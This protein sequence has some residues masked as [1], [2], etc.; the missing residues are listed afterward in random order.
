MSAVTWKSRQWTSSTAVRSMQML[1][2]DAAATFVAIEAAWWIRF[3]GRVPAAD[4][5]A[6]AFSV[7]VVVCARVL[8]LLAAG[9]HRWSF[10]LPGRSEAVRLLV[11]Q[12]AASV[13]FYLLMVAFGV[14][15]P[16]SIYPLEFLVSSLLIVGFRYGPDVFLGWRRER[17][18]LRAGNLSR[19]LIVGAG[20]AGALLARDIRQNEQSKYM[21][22]GFVDDDEAKIGTHLVGRPVLGRPDDLPELLRS[23]R[24]TSVLVAISKLP[25]EQVRRLLDL[26]ASSQTSL[27]I[28]PTSFTEMDA[29]VSAAKLHD[30][31]PEDLLP[32]ESV[33]FDA[34]EIR[35]RVEGRTVLVTGAGGSIGGEIARQLAALGAGTLV[36]VD[37][38]E[39]EL[40]LTARLLS[41]D[42]PF[43]TVHPEVA[44]IREWRRL[45][46][47]GER[48]RP[49]YVF[50]AA[51]HKHVPLMEEAPEE[52]IKNNVFGTR[53]VARMAVACGA[54]RFVLIS[55]DKAVS[56]TSV[57][58]ASKRIAEM[59]VRDLAR[60]STTRMTAVRF[61]NVLG[62][63]GS[64]IPIF[65][66][67]IERGGPV[68]L[69]H[70]DCTRYFM[71]TREA[72]GLVLLAGVRCE[73]DLCLLEMGAPMR[74]LDLA[75]NLI[76]MAG[77][78]PGEDIPIIFTGLRPGERL[79]EELLSEDE[80]ETGPCRDGIRVAHGTPPPPL[81]RA[82][83]AALRSA[84]YAGE[85]AELLAIVE[86]LV[87]SAHLAGAPRRSRLRRTARTAEESRANGH[88]RE[89]E[90]AAGAGASG[91]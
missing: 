69:T 87:P 66:R 16:R 83:L 61:G 32:R 50:H 85:T 35:R 81:F 72:V 22:V 59:V 42:H 75:R 6:L 74:I 36:L 3:E 43:V 57:M 19:T 14:R 7:R 55:T 39:N 21:L 91:A 49:Q 63:A 10:R 37:M 13:A 46:K 28:L 4:A 89:G 45:G 64:V 30:V 1:C 34:D 47:L 76:T 27:K 29:R 68:T 86:D 82:R 60:R 88:A 33:V 58:G 79:C 78:V 11:A 41:E 51:A 84:A 12:G 25:P 56:P 73:S 53:N 31:A 44:D 62:S 26:C 18:R 52:A 23:Y 77:R 9:L 80:E 24:I 17:A 38:N 90:D 65:K 71:T 48:H 5:A 20:E 2:F 8:A 15:V 67:Q 70:P 40:Y 54:Q